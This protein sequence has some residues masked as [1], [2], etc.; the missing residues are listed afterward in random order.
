MSSILNGK[1]KNQ[2]DYRKK[3]DYE[4]IEEIEGMF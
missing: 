1:T 3:I 2:L 4:R